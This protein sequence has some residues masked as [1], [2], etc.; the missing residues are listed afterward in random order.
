MCP[1]LVGRTHAALSSRR[2][3]TAVPPPPPNPSA[4]E[5]EDVLLRT[6][7]KMEHELQALKKQQDKSSGDLAAIG[8]LAAGI[9]VGIML[10]G[11]VGW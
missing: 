9:F 2:L 11:I 1:L 10:K 6:L 7:Q 3:S 8:G 5:D 4:K